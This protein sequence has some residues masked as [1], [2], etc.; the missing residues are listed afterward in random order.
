MRMKASKMKKIILFIT[1]T[2]AILIAASVVVYNFVDI[3]NYKPEI[4]ALVKKQTGNDISITGDIRLRVLPNIAIDISNVAMNSP[5]GDG[6]VALT[7]S[8]IILD[9]KLIPLLQKKVEVS[10]LQLVRPVVNYNILQDGTN[11]FSNV[12][13]E[14]DV[15]TKENPQA[16][17]PEKSGDEIREM[18]N[19]QLIGRLKLSK[20]SIE[21]AQI[22]FVDEQKGSK[23][24]LEKCNFV[25]SFLPGDN[26]IKISGNINVK[27][28]VDIPF[29][30][31]GKYNLVK[32]F[33]QA[34]DLE[35]KF[36]DILTHG[37]VSA[38]FRGNMPDIKTAFYFDEFNFNPYLALMSAASAHKDVVAEEDKS[39]KSNKPKAGTYYWSTAPIDFGILRSFNGR[40]SFK[41]NK[42]TYQ[43]TSIGSV[44]ASA[45][46]TNGKLTVNLR[47][48]EV[49]G[50]NINGE[51]IIDVVSSVP[52]IAHK[53]NI[54]EV[55]FT[56][57][58]QGLGAINKI[59][60]R[61]SGTVALNTR[62]ASQKE[63]IDNVGGNV[64]FKVDGGYIK[65]IDLIAMAKNITAAFIAGARADQQTEFQQLSSDFNVEKGVLRTD[66]LI[67]SSKIL[68]FAGRGDINLPDLS[69]DF[70]MIPKVKN[71]EDER[72]VLGG[73]RAPIIISG[74]LLQPSYRLEV[75]AIVED[76]IK[77]PKSTENLVKQLKRDFKGIKDNIKSDAKGGDGSVVNDLKNILKGF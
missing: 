56:R 72:D 57:F 43:E 2:L 71:V 50:G 74:D 7:I 20:I 35:I 14:T 48:A 17:A 32:D 68:D 40:V 27:S 15:T 8:Q 9:L 31:G 36:G 13:V 75:Q 62:G 59:G 16:A 12:P 49:F 70:R 45:Y 4:V 3:N 55:D 61:V 69:I 34:S 41:S 37:E 18:I 51:S 5:S 64:N 77:N 60:G 22:K 47:D 67:F 19:Q 73:V 46:L 30:I 44:E 76:L 6:N 54:S 21:D 33:Y 23:I 1:L 65:G 26:Q 66:N 53:Y 24:L 63:F 58:P 25:T 29:S 39:S 38:D 42:I 11:N 10:S 28:G 52:K